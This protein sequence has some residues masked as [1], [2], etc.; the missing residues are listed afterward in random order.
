MWGA[1]GPFLL[2]AAMVVVVTP[3]V[4]VLRLLKNVIKTLKLVV[5][6]QYLYLLLWKNCLITVT[7]LV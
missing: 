5:C 4:F 2:V 1:E 7:L 6:T 3:V